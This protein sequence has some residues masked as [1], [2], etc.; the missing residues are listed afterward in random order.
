MMGAKEVI[1]YFE[2]GYKVILGS[3]WGDQEIED[4]E[5]ISEVFEESDDKVFVK[6]V[7]IDE[8]AKEVYI[9]IEIDE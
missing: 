7:E 9:F 2:D 5:E 3:Y 1:K 4:A 6:S 8:V